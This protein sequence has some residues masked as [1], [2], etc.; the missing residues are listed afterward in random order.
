MDDWENF[1]ETLLPEKEDFYSHIN[2]KYITN[3]DYI[4][5]KTVCKDFKST[6]LD[7]YDLDVQSDTVLLGDVFNNFQNMCLEI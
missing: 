1:N 5:A 4:Q 6:N 7:K 3:A 2:M